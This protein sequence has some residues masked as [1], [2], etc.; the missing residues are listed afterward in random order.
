M[1]QYYPVNWINGMKVSSDHFIALENHFINQSQNIVRGMINNLSYGLIPIDDKEKNLPRF[2]LLMNEEKLR[3]LRPLTALTPQGDLVQ[4]P[5]DIEFDL[6]KPGNTQPPFY[7]VLS[8]NSYNRISYGEINEQESPLRYPFALP[9]YKI[10][11]LPVQSNTFH[12]L[13]NTII[14]IA[15]FSSNSMD[16]DTSYIPPCTSIQSSPALISLYNEVQKSFARIEQTVYELLKKPLITNKTLLIS[17]VEFFNQNKPAMDWYIQYL[18]PVFLFEK[19]VQISSIIYYYNEIEVK[20]IKDE[21]TRKYLAQIVN[22]KYNHLEIGKAV[23]VGNTFIDI[24]PRILPKDDSR[25]R[26]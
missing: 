24:A 15:K 1:K 20:Q 8:V 13:G 18:S 10:Q 6:Q 21:E 5:S 26:V 12:V 4:I 17:L 19:I 22:F 25:I 9:E 3:M 23:S 14:P 7:L 11:F 16:E 2:S